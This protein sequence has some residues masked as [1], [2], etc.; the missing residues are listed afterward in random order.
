MQD[1]INTKVVALVIRTGSQSA[2]LTSQVLMEAMKKFIE[3]TRH[4]GDGIRHGKQTVGQLMR[5]NTGLTNLEIT[6]QNQRKDRN[7]FNIEK[8]RSASDRNTWTE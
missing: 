4:Q 5:Q 2:K 7:T 6:D 3:Q 8:D 1:E